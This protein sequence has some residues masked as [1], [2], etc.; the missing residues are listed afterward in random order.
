VKVRRRREE[1]ERRGAGEGREGKRGR[2]GSRKWVPE[3]L[4]QRG[5]NAVRECERVRGEGSCHQLL[6]PARD[7]PVRGRDD[8]ESHCRSSA[9]EAVVLFTG[10]GLP[11]SN[12]AAVSGRRASDVRGPSTSRQANTLTSSH[13]Q[14]GTRICVDGRSSRR[15]TGHSSIETDEERTQ[16]KQASS[17]QST[18]PYTLLLTDNMCPDAISKS[19]SHQPGSSHQ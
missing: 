10:A 7:R 13:R 18:R 2:A 14:P 8:S 6:P 12:W 16:G 17:A 5:A 11:I 9:S 1:S 4:Q 3:V 19:Q 15:T